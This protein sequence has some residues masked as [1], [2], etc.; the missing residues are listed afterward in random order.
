MDI[1]TS[2]AGFGIR[3]IARLIDI[4][5]GLILGF[6]IGVIV[7]VIFA[8]LA[9]LGKLS[10][11]WPTL[12][13][14]NRISGFAL[15]LLGALLYHAVSEGIGGVTLGKTICGLRV[16]QMD[17]RPVTFKGAFMRD[18]AYY[19][20]GLFFGVIAYNSMEKGP[21]HQRY[22]DVWG[23]TVVVKSS[24]FQPE[25]RRSPFRMFLGICIGS[26][27]WA[28]LLALGMIIKVI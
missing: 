7:G 28:A 23:K 10:S 26:L 11:D 5:Y 1:P 15:S 13:R 3:V 12:V 14:Q 2:G 21:L 18:L 6:V 27:P 25:P 20:D 17:G 4:V 16:V 9:H 8:I 22:G 24:A 19:W